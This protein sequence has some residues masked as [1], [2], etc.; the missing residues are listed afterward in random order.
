MGSCGLPRTT[1]GGGRSAPG[2]YLVAAPQR[3]LWG[4]MPSRPSY[5]CPGTTCATAQQ[6]QAQPQRQLPPAPPR[7]QRGPGGCG[8]RALR[9]TSAAPGVAHAPL[10]TPE[11]LATTGISEKSSR[12]GQRL[13]RGCGFRICLSGTGTGTGGCGGILPACSGADCT[14]AGRWRRRRGPRS[15]LCG[16]LGWA[17]FTG[18]PRPTRCS[19][20]TALAPGTPRARRGLHPPPP[21]LF[22]LSCSGLPRL[23]ET[24]HPLVGRSA[25]AP[26]A[27]LSGDPASP[28]GDAL[29]AQGRS[30]TQCF[31]CVEGSVPDTAIL[32]S[33]QPASRGV[34]SGFWDEEPEAPGRGRGK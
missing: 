6:V 15:Q 33:L 22:W 20:P 17:A 4:S 16:A 11:T 21:T 24:R 7:G 13:W 28:C 27:V 10:G 32:S 31:L 23:R 25:T 19:D 18:S 34:S 2:S 3:S 26:T 29:D 5:S 30:S 1:G 14:L 8:P 12:S 9:E